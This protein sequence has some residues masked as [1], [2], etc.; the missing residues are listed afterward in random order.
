MVSTSEKK[1]KGFLLYRI[2]FFLVIIIN[3][4]VIMWVQISGI[5]VMSTI[6]EESH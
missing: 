3:D 1:T 5:Q 6:L 4:L 2:L